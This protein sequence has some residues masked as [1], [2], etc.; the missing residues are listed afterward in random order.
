MALDSQIIDRVFSSPQL[1]SLPAIALKIIELVQQDEGDID[2]IAETISLDAALSTKLLKTVNSSFYGLPKTVGSMNQAVMVLGLNSVKTLALGFSLVQNL[3]DAGGSSFDHAAYWRRGLYSATAAKKLCEQLNIVQAEE[4]FMASMLQDVGVLALSQ[5]LESQYTAMIKQTRGNHSQLSALERETLGADHAQVGAALAESWG[6]PPL[7]VESIRLHESA[8]EAPGNLAPLIRTV[9]AGG[10]VAELIDHP[11]DEQHVGAFHRVMKDWFELDQA[12][13]ESLLE[14][15]F[16]HAGEVQRVFDLPTGEL[17][18]AATILEKASEAMNRVKA[19]A[20]S[21]KG[22]DKT[23]PTPAAPKSPEPTQSIPTTTQDGLTGL[24][25]RRSFEEKLDE[26]FV[27]A[28]DDQPLSVVYVDIDQFDKVNDT[29]GRPVGDTVLRTV[30]EALRVSAGDQGV[31]YRFADDDFTVLC[32]GVSR[33][34]A[35]LL[36]EQLR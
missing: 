18:D 7:L 36:A 17:P 32:P 2:S 26:G 20:A 1:P 31:V 19:Q 21:A 13:A 24:P 5:V 9:Q 30:A 22:A 11:N 34:D 23:A 4:I 15:V 27:T 6:L 35:A 33:S 16:Q 10:L 3:T 25:G 14:G 8:D 29:H 28:G 12:Q